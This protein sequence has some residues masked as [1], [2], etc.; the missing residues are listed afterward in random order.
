MWL[1]TRYFYGCREESMFI[2]ENIRLYIFCVAH[3]I[4]T[5]K[6]KDNNC[7][8]IKAISKATFLNSIIFSFAASIRY[9]C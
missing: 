3:I 1:E 5:K 2:K 9:S 4:F 6:I 7:V 8:D